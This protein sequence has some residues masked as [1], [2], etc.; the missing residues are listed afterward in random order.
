[1]EKTLDVRVKEI[2]SKLHTMPEIGFAEFKTSAFLADALK[3]AGYKTQTGIGGTGV[4]G[5]LDSGQPGSTLAIRA[6]MDALAHMVDGKECAIHSCGHDAHSAMVLTVAEHLAAR[7]IRRGRVK[8]IFQ[9]AEEKL[10]GALRVIEAGVIDDVD[11]LLGIHLRPGQEAKSGQAVPALYHASSYIVEADIHGLAAHGARPHLGVN[12]IDAAAAVINAINAIH[13]DPTVPHS[14]KTTKMQAGGAA[15][16]AI[17]DKAQMAFDLRCQQ[18]SLMDELIQ[19]VKC[20]IEAGAAS[21]GAKAVV[22][23][24]G[25]VPAAEYDSGITELAKEAITACLGA[26]GLLE[27]VLT[28]GGED[29]HFYIKHKSSLKTGYIG[30]G[31][32]LTPGLHHPAMQFDQNSLINGVN[33]LLY[34]TDKLI[35]ICE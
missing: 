10:F 5:L 35:G 4:V 22:T 13:L 2:W 30:L 27:P 16:N 34:M 18:N 26:D 20:A 31:C 14:V 19:K 23:V 24:T 21:V 8:I 25:G 32:D 11:I 15:L 17:P 6:D 3:K 7:G 29:F 1:M 12:V 33:I 9:P 28:P